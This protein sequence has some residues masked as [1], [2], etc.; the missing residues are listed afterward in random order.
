MNKDGMPIIV[1]HYDMLLYL[2]YQVS[3]VL[4]KDDTRMEILLGLIFL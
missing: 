4:V 3:E 2:Q 1:K